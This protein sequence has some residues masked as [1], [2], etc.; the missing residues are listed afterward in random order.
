MC[1]NKVTMAKNSTYYNYSKIIFRKTSSLE[2]TCQDLG[3]DEKLAFL[4]WKVLQQAIATYKVIWDY[5]Y[6]L[7]QNIHSIF[8]ELSMELLLS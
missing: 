4:I 6:F 5:Y 7:Q 2:E 3:D 1:Q 8:V